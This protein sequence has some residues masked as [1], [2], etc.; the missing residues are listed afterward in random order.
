MRRRG[1]RHSAERTL[2]EALSSESLPP[3]P[4]PS[5]HSGTCE[6]SIIS[7]KLQGMPASHLKKKTFP[8]ISCSSPDSTTQFASLS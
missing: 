2:S 7:S 1:R 4:S 8:F 6:S 3:L 5:P